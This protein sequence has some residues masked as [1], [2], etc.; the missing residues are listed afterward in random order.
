MFLPPG[1]LLGSSVPMASEGINSSREKKVLR[2]L[3]TLAGPLNGVQ[4]M[5][6]SFSS[7][8]ATFLKTGHI[9]KD[10]VSRSKDGSVQ[11]E[12]QSPLLP[13]ECFSGF[14]K[15]HG[16]RIPC[17]FVKP[18]GQNSAIEPSVFCS[19][20]LY[21]PLDLFLLPD[22]IFEICIDAW[23]FLKPASFIDW[24]FTRFECLGPRGQWTFVRW[25]L[26]FFGSWAKTLTL[27][28]FVPLKLVVNIL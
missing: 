12:I 13:Q 7:W 26:G 9:P 19:S 8:W 4:V 28:S 17:Y 23:C 24:L 2:Q 11:D 22:A 6:R 5:S 16:D 21:C 1:H 15:I 27:S 14:R 10:H 3:S 18:L 20:T 25:C